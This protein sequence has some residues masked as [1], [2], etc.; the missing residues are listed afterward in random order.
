MRGRRG[1]Y[2]RGTRSYKRNFWVR[3]ELKFVFLENE[4]KNGVSSR[5]TKAGENNARVVYSVHTGCV[6]IK[7][8][9]LFEKTPLIMLTFSLLIEKFVRLNV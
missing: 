7:L 5:D 6:I 4:R 2:R 3:V 8:G 9:V 1:K